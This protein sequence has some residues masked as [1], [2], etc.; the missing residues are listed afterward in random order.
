MARW[1]QRQEAHCALNLLC[2]TPAL[3]LEGMQATASSLEMARSELLSARLSAAN[4]TLAEAAGDDRMGG[5][6]PPDHRTG[7]GWPAARDHA[8]MTVHCALVGTV[9]ICPSAA[10]AV[11]SGPVLADWVRWAGVVVAIIGTAVAAPA[12]TALIWRRVR[13]GL[14]K[15]VRKVHVFLARF[16]PFLRRSATA[17]GHQPCTRWEW[18]AAGR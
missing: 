15:A 1:A 9:L 14:Q 13:S 12:G 10:H 18:V 6:W 5:S 17:H 4:R 8:G 3:A 16:L 7:R 11:A 2:L